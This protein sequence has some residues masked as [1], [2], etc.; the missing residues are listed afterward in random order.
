MEIETSNDG[1]TWDTVWDATGPQTTTAHESIDTGENVGGEEFYISF[2]VRTQS[3]SILYW[4]FD[5][6]E[7]NGYPLMEPE[8]TDEYCV[9]DLEVGEELT[10]NFD[11]W[12]PE[13]LALGLNS[14]VTYKASIWTDMQSPPDQQ[15]ANDAYDRFCELDYFHDVGIQGVASPADDPRGDL[16]YAYNAYDPSG[17]TVVGP[18]YF[19]SED[20]GILESLKAT[21]SPNFIAGADWID[22]E[23]IGC[24]YDNGQLWRIDHETG[25]MEKFGQTGSGLNGLAYCDKTKTLYGA[26]SYNLYEIDLETGKQT[27]IGAFSG[28]SFLA[29][30]IAIDAKGICYMHDIVTDSIYLVDLEDASC[31]LLGST[32]ISCNYAQDMAYD[33]GNDAMYLAAYTS[34]GQLY[35]MDMEN[36]KATFIG[37]FKGGAE[38]TGFAIPGGMGV[39][40]ETYVAPGTYD[41]DVVVENIGTFP[42]ED[43]C[44]MADIVE[45]NTDCENA[46]HTGYS[47]TITGIDILTPLGG[48]E[49]LEFPDFFFADEGFYGILLNL[50][51]ID[52][53]VDLANNVFAYGVGVDDTPPSSGHTLDPPNPDGLNGWYVSDLEV[54]VSASDPSIGCDREGSGVDYIVYEID[55]DQG[56]ID[57]DNGIFTI[58]QEDDGDDVLVEYWAVDNV[59]NE[60]TP[61]NT[62]RIDMDQTPPVIDLTYE[63]TGTAP[64][65]NFIFT[66]NST[67]ATSGM[68][69]VE[70]HLNA[71]LQK[72]VSG[73]GPEYVWELL[74]V[75]I[76]VAIFKST[77]YDFA[78]LF[79]FDTVRDP[80]T[81]SKNLKTG[82]GTS[83]IGS[84]IRLPQRI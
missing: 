66:A 79:A 48:E 9:S 40:L 21:T 45:F 51:C 50:T 72:V 77:G 18:C 22:G 20:P 44:A 53:D 70:F 15:G 57:G 5:N 30:A 82:G 27:N 16:W 43:L 47:E 61:H 73:P 42:E 58:T 28:G 83:E 3:Y 76:P 81:T 8:Y 34:Q 74:Y 63:Y 13:H 6:L 68:E 25:D 11:D 36:G 38:M 1:T 54:T 4:Y 12:T 31:T 14:Q 33:R 2:T 84:T 35:S 19:D 69:R 24:Q 29:I 64:P 26:G 37:S 78:G 7:I 75:P 55:G 56:T 67:D 46:T 10:I 41:V 65:Y 39:P 17:Q 71:E 32:G 59:G 52:N 62:F 60:E 80:V 23:W 49:T